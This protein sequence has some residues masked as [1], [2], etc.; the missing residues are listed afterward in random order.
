MLCCFLHIGSIT[1][2]AQDKSNNDRYNDHYTGCW[3][4]GNGADGYLVTNADRTFRWIKPVANTAAPDTLQG[5]WRI[6]SDYAIPFKGDIIVLKF[7]G[8]KKKKYP[9]GG[10]QHP[11]VIYLPGD[12]F[13]KIPCK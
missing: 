10:I 8:G 12:D 1:S 13:H 9:I 5:R 2:T 11:A 6:T 4:T 7:S 3:E